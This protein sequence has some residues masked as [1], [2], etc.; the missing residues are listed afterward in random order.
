MIYP[1][2]NL[3]ESSLAM[4]PTAMKKEKKQ[5]K[6]KKKKKKKNIATR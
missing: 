3:T 2:T 6:E 4:C 1:N 5:R